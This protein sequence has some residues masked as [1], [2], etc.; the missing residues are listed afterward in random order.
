ME[1]DK[2]WELM[3]TLSTTPSKIPI[4]L[5]LVPQE[6]PYKSTDDHY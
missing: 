6:F 5:T 3:K 1:R 2:N 4:Q